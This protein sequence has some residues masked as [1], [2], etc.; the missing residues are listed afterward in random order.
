MIDYKTLAAE[1]VLLNGPTGKCDRCQE[2]DYIT[3]FS[4][5]FHNSTKDY[6]MCFPCADQTQ[7]EEAEQWREYYASVL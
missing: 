5:T 1:A 4:S 6:I 7:K 3:D 2:I